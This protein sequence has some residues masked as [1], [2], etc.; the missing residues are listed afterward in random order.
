[1]LNI[2]SPDG[3][4]ERPAGEAI[5]E[6]TRKSSRFIGSSVVLSVVFD[7]AEAFLS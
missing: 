1:M 5:E 3:E 7:M 4:G 6:G 2:F